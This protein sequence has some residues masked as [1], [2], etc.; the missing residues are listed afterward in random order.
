[1]KLVY[2]KQKGG[3]VAGLRF[4]GY[5]MWLPLHHTC[6][7]CPCSP[8]YS[9]ISD[10]LCLVPGRLENLKGWTGCLYLTKGIARTSSDYV[11]HLLARKAGSSLCWQNLRTYK[12]HLF[13][14]VDLMNPR[15]IFLACLR[16]DS[17][18][19][20]PRSFCQGQDVSL[21][22]FLTFLSLMIA[23]IFNYFKSIVPDPWRASGI[24]TSAML[25]QECKSLRIS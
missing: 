19:S 25:G 17:P 21:D 14:Q 12:A 18:V 15:V 5:R 6:R 24:L 3:K 20:L 23:E 1:M 8:R 2:I 9:L 22:L 4:A 13:F 16:K 11:R 10:K 7:F